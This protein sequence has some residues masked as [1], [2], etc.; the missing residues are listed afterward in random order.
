MPRLM[1]GSVLL[2]IAVAFISASSAVAQSSY[3]VVTSFPDNAFFGRS[4]EAG[5][6]QGDDGAFYGV[7]NSGGAFNAGTV[8][9]ASGG[10]VT[11]LHHFNGVDGGTPYSRLIQ[12]SDGNFYGTTSRGG[13]AVR[14]TT[15]VGDGT[16]FRVDASGAFSSLHRFEGSDGSRPMAGVIQASDGMF[17]GTTANGGEFGLGTVFRLDARTG[18]LTTLYSFSGADGRGPMASLIQAGD[19][20]FYG[21]TQSGGQFQAGTIFRIDFAGMLTTVHHFNRPDGVGPTTELLEASDGR[22]Y[23]TT[24]FGGESA[25][26]GGTLFRLDAA[27]TFTVLHHFSNL[28]GEGGRPQ[29]GLT[30]AGDGR[31]Y[32]TITTGIGSLGTVF[33]FDAAGGMT[34]LPSFQNVGFPSGRLVQA[35]DGALYGTTSS[36]GIFGAGSIL[37]LDA[38]GAASTVV[39]FGFSTTDGYSP[40]AGL[41]QGADGRLY[42]TTISGNDI[43]FH[44]GTVFTLDEAGSVTILHR[45]H[46]G[47]G[48]RPNAGV[49]QASDGHLYGTLFSTV[50]N[51]PQGIFALDPGGA[52]QMVNRNLNSA[53]GLVEATDGRL[54]GTLSGAVFGSCPALPRACPGGVTSHYFSVEEGSR[55]TDALIQGADGELYG[56]TM[57]GGQF[58]AATQ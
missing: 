12:A 11:V 2:A 41:I 53:A 32:G 16:V 40:R 10:T 43:T 24:P 7:G 25:G 49:I 17:Y 46:P 35:S 37:R 55:A 21:T 42:G 34:I 31:I 20:R 56:T 1:F 23:G 48:L 9:R 29:S 14:G 45:F 5:L 36:G 3:E 27:G 4:P 51:G 54:Y 15:K 50:A 22:F 8:F 57:E 18:I 47:E 26:S 13:N 44:G 39:S 52:F 33:S 19:G 38:S 6:A 28:P 58:G 30:Q